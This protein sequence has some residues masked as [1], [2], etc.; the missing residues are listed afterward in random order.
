MAPS[1][2]FQRLR[3]VL[4]AALLLLG[5]PAPA[6]PSPTQAHLTDVVIIAPLAV[7]STSTI[8]PVSFTFDSAGAVA[9]VQVLTGG[10]ADQ[11]FQLASG[12]TLV[13]GQAHNPGDTASVNLTDPGVPT[14]VAVDGSGNVYVALVGDHNSNAVLEVAP[15]GTPI[16]EIA[17]GPGTLGTVDHLGGL[18]VDWAGNVFV[19]ATSVGVVYRISPSGSGHVTEARA[20]GLN[21][22]TG[23]AVDGAGNLFVGQ[24]IYSGAVAGTHLVKVPFSADAFQDYTLNFPVLN[25]TTPE[26]SIFVENIGNQPLVFPPSTGLVGNPLLLVHGGFYVDQSTTNFSANT[27]AAGDPVADR[28]IV[29]V[30]WIEPQDW[31]QNTATSGG[32]LA[33][34]SNSLNLPEPQSGVQI[35]LAN[36]FAL[37]ESVTEGLGHG[38]AAPVTLTPNNLSPAYTGQPIPVALNAAAPLPSITASPAL[39]AGY[40]VNVTYTYPGGTNPTAT[41]PTDAGIYPFQAAVAPLPGINPATLV[42]GWLPLS[43]TPPQLTI[44]PATITGVTFSSNLT[45]SYSAQTPVTATATTQTPVLS[46]K[47]PIPT[48]SLTN[49]LTKVTY[50]STQLPLPPGTYTVTAA[51][52]GLSSDFTLGSSPSLTTTLTIGPIP[53]TFSFPGLSAATPYTG[54]PVTVT[55]TPS[56]TVSGLA[57]PGSDIVLTYTGPSNPPTTP[58]SYTVTATVAASNPYYQ[59]TTS[60]GFSILQ[61]TVTGVTFGNAVQ[62]LGH[63]LPVTATAVPASPAPHLVLSFTSY[64]PFG[65]PVTSSTQPRGLGSYTVTATVQDPDF[66]P[67][68]FTGTLEIETPGGKLRPEIVLAGQGRDGVI[69]LT[70]AQLPVQVSTVPAGLPVTVRYNGRTAPPT[71]PGIYLVEVQALVPGDLPAVAVALLELTR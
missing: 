30:G 67:A 31:T 54:S 41:A 61:A 1:T 70:L 48:L 17:K 64:P 28:M 51:F 39:P 46:S 6:A 35:T 43:G 27:I 38:P 65:P 45:Q 37:A 44:Q 53:V 49:T 14:G 29:T 19:C 26:Q 13:L 36:T 3:P 55:A 58:G 50:H 60:L 12:G 11:D 63:F 62:T 68:S 20:A 7:G 23:V 52:S 42:K 25:G 5:R 15:D 22:P 16:G 8:V 71:R 56:G 40:S 18:A 66:L 24:T 59:G 57:L 21:N 33:F 4:A 10:A 32:G 34:L 2:L 47:L 69:H 9:T